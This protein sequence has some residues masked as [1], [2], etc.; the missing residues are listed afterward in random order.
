M[1]MGREVVWDLGCPAMSSSNP[2]QACGASNVHRS[3]SSKCAL[4]K[5]QIT[6]LPNAATS[7]SLFCVLLSTKKLLAICVGFV[8]SCDLVRAP[9]PGWLAAHP[10]QFY[11]RRCPTTEARGTKHILL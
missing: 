10:E 2:I 9:S 5:G 11:S 8:R 6:A 4:C 7:L 1:G 3:V